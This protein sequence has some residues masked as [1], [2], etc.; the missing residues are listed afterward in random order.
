VWRTRCFFPNGRDCQAELAWV[1]G[2]NARI[3]CIGYKLI[4]KSVIH[5][6]VLSGLDVRAIKCHRRLVRVNFVDE[7]SAVATTQLTARLVVNL[8]TYTGLY[9]HKNYRT[10]RLA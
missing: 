9:L 1:A 10:S 6:S 2:F 8:C 5:L 7:T 4:C 3:N